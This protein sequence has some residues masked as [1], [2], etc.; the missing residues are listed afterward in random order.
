[1]D[2]LTTMDKRDIRKLSLHEAVTLSI[3][4]C[5]RNPHVENPVT[6]ATVVEAA[7]MFEN[8]LLGQEEKEAQ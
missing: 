2:D 1:M 4:L 5:A 8:Y 7:R 6:S 3:A